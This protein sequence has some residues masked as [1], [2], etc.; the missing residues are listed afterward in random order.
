MYF[1]KNNCLYNKY[2]SYY[3]EIDQIS[4]TMAAVSNAEASKFF[5]EVDTS[6]DGVVSIQELRGSVGAS[7]NDE[8]VAVS[9]MY[10]MC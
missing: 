8:Q 9:M 3:T 2:S 5:D 6:G 4:N 1:L 10:T 7:Y